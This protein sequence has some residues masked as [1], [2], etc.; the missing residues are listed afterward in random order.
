MKALISEN[1]SREDMQQITAS[2]NFP[3]LCEEGSELSQ[4]SQRRAYHFEEALL[5]QE[6]PG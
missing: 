4:K 1:L 5:F 3:P 6:S 2:L